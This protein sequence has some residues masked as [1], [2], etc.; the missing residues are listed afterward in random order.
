MLH[1]QAC[2]TRHYTTNKTDIMN[3]KVNRRK[4]L[5]IIIP[6]Y[7]VYS[8]FMAIILL[9]EKNFHEDKSYFILY[10]IFFIIVIP[11]LTMSTFKKTIFR[12]RFDDNE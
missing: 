1:Q 10:G 6:L 4:W 8:I 2:E 11:I 5:I 12:K 9:K 3:K 7:I